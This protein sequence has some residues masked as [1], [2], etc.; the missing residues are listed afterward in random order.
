MNFRGSACF[1]LGAGLAGLLGVGVSSDPGVVCRL[2][3]GMPESFWSYPALCFTVWAYG[4]PVGLILAATGVLLG[5]GAGAGRALAF[6][7]PVLAGYLFIAIVNDPMPHVPVL[8]G[9]GGALILLFYFSIL[10]IN[11][12]DLA[13]NATKL[14]GYTFLV[15]GFWFTCGLGSRQYHELLDSGQSPIDIMTY[16]VLAMGLL[17]LGEWQAQRGRAGRPIRRDGGLQTG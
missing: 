4:V 15:T 14:A 11:A 7:V 8:F 2:S 3:G 16:F 9:I 10:W 1:W 17:C 13:A 12:G 6:F 5:S